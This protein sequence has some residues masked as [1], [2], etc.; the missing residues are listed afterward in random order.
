M[1]REIADAVTV[2][3][4]LLPASSAVAATCTYQFFDKNGQLSF[5]FQTRPKWPSSAAQILLGTPNLAVSF[6]VTIAE[7]AEHRRLSSATWWHL[8]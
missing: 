4:T 3:F 7:K 1:R 2:F 5:P 8:Q 6:L